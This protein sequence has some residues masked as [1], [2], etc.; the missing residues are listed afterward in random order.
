MKKGVDKMQF[1]RGVARKRKKRLKKHHK[2]S[3]RR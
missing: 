2:Q 3:R 1:K